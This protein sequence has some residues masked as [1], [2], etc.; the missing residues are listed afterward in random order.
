MINYMALLGIHFQ[1]AAVIGGSLRM[2][3][4]KDME[5]TSG[6][7]E[8]DTRANTS[9]VIFTGMEYADGEMEQCIMENTNRVRWMVMDITGF[10][11]AMKSTESTRMIRNRERESLKRVTNYS[12]S[13]MTKAT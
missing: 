3:I 10:H 4:T 7:M 11:L 13:T 9:S 6:L 1:E 2:A 12:E 5:H 8:R